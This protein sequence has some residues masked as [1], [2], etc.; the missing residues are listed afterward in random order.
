MFQPNSHL[1]SL[2]L[3]SQ[4]P[5][6]EKN[7]HFDAKNGAASGLGEGSMM[8]DPQ[9]VVKGVPKVSAKFKINILKTVGENP[10][11]VDTLFG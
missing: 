9:I 3:P 6:D 7:L 5:P 2:N 11:S 1:I 8:S 4:G 10:L